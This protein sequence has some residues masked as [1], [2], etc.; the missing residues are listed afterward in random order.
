MDTQ[1]LE[2]LAHD[3]DEGTILLVG[4]EQTPDPA[5]RRLPRVRRLPALPYDELPGLAREA[6]VLMMPYADL[7]VTR[8][9]QPLKLLEYLATGR[10]VVASDL[11]STRPWSDGLDLAG[12]PEAFSAAVLRRI[13][14]GIPEDQQTARCRLVYEGWD[15]KACQFERWAIG[16]EA[17]LTV[18]C[19]D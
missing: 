9:M 4:P 13:A 2:R 17:V 5:L 12:S 15:A 6:A 7:P 19:H 1:F 8:A 10:P 3:L 18:S 14:G 16:S 11:P